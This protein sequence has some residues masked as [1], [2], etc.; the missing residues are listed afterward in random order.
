MRM[1][2]LAAV[3]AISLITAPVAAATPSVAAPPL[4][5]R[6]GAETGSANEL[7]GTTAWIL[8]AIALGLIVW[9]IIELTS[10]DEDFPTSP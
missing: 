5:Q 6:A 3:A 1:N 2:G 9:G 8:A 7:V 10:D 4:A